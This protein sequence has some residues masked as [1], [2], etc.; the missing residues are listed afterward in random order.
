MNVCDFYDFWK[1]V[2]T[3]FLGISQILTVNCEIH[4]FSFYLLKNFCFPV[5]KICARKVQFRIQT[6]DFSATREIEL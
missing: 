6:E 2:A 3:A 5:T 4:S 1:L